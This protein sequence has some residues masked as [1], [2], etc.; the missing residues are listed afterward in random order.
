MIKFKTKT[1]FPILDKRGKTIGSYIIRL[2]VNNINV[3]I[4]GAIATGFYY[5]CNEDNNEITLDSFKSDFPWDLVAVAESKLPPLGSTQS[6]KNNIFQRVPEFGI[7]QQMI[8]SGENYGTV[9]TDWE[10]D[11][12]YNLMMRK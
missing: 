7:M 12:E 3:D 6:L 4:N 11:A 1:E 8:E 9:G 5:Y 10:V 2:I